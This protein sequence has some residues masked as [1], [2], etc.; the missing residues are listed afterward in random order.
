[1]PDTNLPTDRSSRA[2]FVIFIL[3]VLLLI[4]GGINWGVTGVRM[5]V[6]DNGVEVQD[7]LEWTTYWGQVT[8][9]LAVFAASLIVLILLILRL[10]QPT[11]NGKA[12]MPNFLKSA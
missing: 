4:V 9:Y 3:A 8:I 7:M 10:A 11:V 1:M 2:A 5:I 12:I 6:D